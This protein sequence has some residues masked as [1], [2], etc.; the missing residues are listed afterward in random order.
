MSIY[1]VYDAARLIAPL[2]V[3]VICSQVNSVGTR[4]VIVMGHSV[5]LTVRLWKLLVVWRSVF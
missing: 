5:P 2:I 3:I 4:F 1:R